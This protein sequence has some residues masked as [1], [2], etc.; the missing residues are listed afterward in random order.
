M[1]IRTERVAG[2]VQQAIARLFQQDFSD[3]SDGMITVTKVRMAPDLK[4]GR[5]Y[6]SI[7]GGELP[8]AE[9]LKRIK[10]A[11]PQIRYA[12]AKAINMKFSP[13]LFYYLDD[14]AEE[15]STIE[16]IFRKIREEAEAKAPKPEDQADEQANESSGEEKESN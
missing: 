14:T 5:V 3:V 15:V 7:L 6:L 11:A 12:L 2:E 9:T 10:A 16:D 8:G 13:E 4:S 1:S